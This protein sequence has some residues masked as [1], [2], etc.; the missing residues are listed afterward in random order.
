MDRFER[1]G[2]AFARLCEIMAHLRAPDGC[3]WDREQT[4]QTLRS[5]LLEETYET[6]EALD[7]RDFDGHREELGD[8]LLQIVFQTQ[9]TH[10]ERRFDIADVCDGI[11]D[12]LVHRH[13]HVFARERAD[14]ADDAL[15]TWERQKAAERPGRSRLDG[16]PPTLPALLRALRVGEKAAAIGFDWPDASGVRAKVEE[17]WAE[18]GAARGAE[19]EEELGDMLFALSSLAR[20]LRVDPEGAL[21]GATDKFARRFRAVETR[22]S[23]LGT[24]PMKMS[25]DELE[26]LWEDAK[27]LD[28]EGDK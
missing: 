25:V 23:E 12:K 20:H 18:L 14:D 8:L 21:R 6:L 7:R 3:P 1:A 4:L 10:E 27:S 11:S 15:H 17:E 13:P 22:L 16:V 2:R 9:I 28:L 26:S 5:Y 24:D 19:I